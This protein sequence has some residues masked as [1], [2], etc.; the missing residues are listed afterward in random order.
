MESQGKINIFE[1]F[2]QNETKTMYYKTEEEGLLTMIRKLIDA[3]ELDEKHGVT[4]G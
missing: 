4:N 3:K 1:F 2:S